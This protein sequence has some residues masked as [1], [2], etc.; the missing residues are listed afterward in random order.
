MGILLLSINNSKK[1]VWLICSGKHCIL[2]KRTGILK[3]A[4]INV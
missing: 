1:I 3:G 2:K 4:F